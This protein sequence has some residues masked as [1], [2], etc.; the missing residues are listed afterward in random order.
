MNAFLATAGSAL[1]MD[2]V[3]LTL[4]NNYHQSLFQKIQQSPL[5]ARVIPA[6]AIYML[7]PLALFIGAVQPASTVIDGMKRGA[8]IGLFLY[9]FYDLTNYATLTQ[10]T[11]QMTV[12]DI[13]WGTFLCTL[14]AGV[15]A[16]V[17]K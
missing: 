6:I 9:A 1:L 2:G 8:L 10:W 16:Y 4:R 7:I 3:W 5:K 11:L 14:A 15:G 13:L 17:K 12:T